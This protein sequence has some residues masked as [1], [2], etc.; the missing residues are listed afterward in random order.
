MWR[1]APS[2]LACASLAA[3]SSSS[4]SGTS[5]AVDCSFTGTLSGGLAAGIIADGCGG[6]GGASFSIAQT[7]FTSGA[8]LSVE[9]TPVTP[10][11]GG[12]LGAIPLARFDVFQTDST[13]GSRAWRSTAC[14]L[15]LDKSTSSPTN[16]FTNRFLLSG[17]GSCP[18]ALDPVAPNTGAAVTVSDFTL[19]GFINPH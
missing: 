16:V 7:D 14:T 2:V 8:A 19:T 13:G 11:K 9:L 4:S 10:L 18:A 15:A 1:L 12:E 6:S 3:C 17:H 5:D